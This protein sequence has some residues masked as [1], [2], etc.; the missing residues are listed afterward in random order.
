VKNSF[1]CLEKNITSSSEPKTFYSSS[2]QYEYETEYNESNIIEASIETECSAEQLVSKKQHS[3][4]LKQSK[5]CTKLLQNIRTSPKKLRRPR[6]S[7]DSSFNCDTK[8]FRCSS[9]CCN[10]LYYGPHKNCKN[11][12]EDITY[13]DLKQSEQ[14]TDKIIQMQPST[15]HLS[16]NNVEE[17]LIQKNYEE[18]YVVIE[19]SDVTRDDTE[20]GDCDST[21]GLNKNETPI[22]ITE[23]SKFSQ[24][25]LGDSES[26]II[27]RLVFDAFR[28]RVTKP[29]VVERLFPSKYH[30]VSKIKDN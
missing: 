10:F 14:N 26:H 18:E 24:F 4:E 19:Q 15:S 5:F 30:A 22:L 23:P 27:A 16:M 13:S 12:Q 9:L 6:K 3:P 11:F 8:C 1:Q 20:N 29:K 25:V 2:S 21:E 28:Q 17:L 7:N